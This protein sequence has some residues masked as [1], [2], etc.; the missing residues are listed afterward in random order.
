MV[1]S[2]KDMKNLEYLELNFKS[3]FLGE[4]P[5]NVKVLFGEI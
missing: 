5:E 1:G 4:N 2:L 3:N